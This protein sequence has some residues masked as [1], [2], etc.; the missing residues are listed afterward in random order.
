MLP[1]ASLLQMILE[2]FPAISNHA[3]MF[4]RW[5]PG[6]YFLE[7]IQEKFLQRRSF[8]KN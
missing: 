3:L 5:K 2:K 6:I 7:N 8:V 4:H 1:V